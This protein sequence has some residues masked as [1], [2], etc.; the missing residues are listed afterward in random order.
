LD[1]INRIYR[2]KRENFFS[3]K[4]A[5]K[6][7]KREKKDAF[8]ISVRTDIKKALSCGERGDLGFEMINM[9]YRMK[10]ELSI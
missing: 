5:R 1:R 3:H 7:T 9:I 10:R 6:S 2:M 4:K 8:V